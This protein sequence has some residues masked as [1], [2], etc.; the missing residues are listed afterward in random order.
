MQSRSTYA[1]INLQ[2]LRH[3]YYSIR[4]S[5]P[6]GVSIMG[7]VKADAYGHGAV[8]IGSELESMGVDFLA[9]AYLEEGVELRK[10]GIKVPII[11][12]CSPVKGNEEDFLDWNLTPV[13]FNINDARS[14]SIA[15]KKRGV[16]GKVHVKVDTG[17]GRLGLLPR[18]VKD[19][20][21]EI[22]LLDGITVEGLLSHF[23]AS[24]DEEQDEFTKEQISLFLKLKEEFLTAGIKP[25]YFHIANSAAIFSYPESL[26]NLV[27]AGIT[28]YGAYPSPS[29]EKKVAL[30]PIMSIK[31]RIVHLKEVGAGFSISYGRTF[32]TKRKSIIGTLSFGYAD[33]YS[34][35]FSNRAYVLVK[36]KK[37]PVVG[38]VCMD[39]TMVDLT[40]IDGVRIGDEVVLLGRQGD[41]EITPQH[42]ADWAETI[43]YEI[44]C[45]IGKRVPR[46]YIHG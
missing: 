26:F 13:V 32:I 41:E 2:A 35:K 17:M 28:L 25:S 15:S 29:F 23:A 6:R 22:L 46:I 31:T 36:G 11:V 20:I 33:G 21:K 37:A 19:F 44:F 39:L 34:R 43:P 40:D 10:A 5:L 1:E 38:R 45:S 16:K 18:E 8:A 3:N 9:V 24:E 4:Q 7:V 27:R 14:L 30:K 12:L 42:W